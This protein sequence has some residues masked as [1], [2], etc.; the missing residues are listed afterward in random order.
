[1]I[2]VYTGLCWVHVQVESWVVKFWPGCF[3]DEKWR[4]AVPGDNHNCEP[5]RARVT[6]ESLKWRIKELVKN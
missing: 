4:L 6:A 5:N 1:M 3:F 2:S